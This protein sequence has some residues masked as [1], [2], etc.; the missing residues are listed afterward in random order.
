MC[1]FQIYKY[2]WPFFIG[3][4]VLECLHKKENKKHKFTIAVLCNIFFYKLVAS[5]V[6]LNFSKVLF[7]SLHLSNSILTCKVTGKHLKRGAGYALRDSSY[8]NLHY[9]RESSSFNHGIITQLYHRKKVKITTKKKE[10]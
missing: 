2:I 10:K 8:L 3:E 9:T 5:N 7:K 6:S 1:G 4:K